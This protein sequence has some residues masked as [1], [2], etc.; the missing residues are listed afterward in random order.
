[1]QSW[2]K[3]WLLGRLHESRIRTHNSIHVHD[4]L[5][6]P[7]CE[8]EGKSTLSLSDVTDTC[9]ASGSGWVALKSGWDLFS[10]LEIN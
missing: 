3:K 6:L 4:P 8:N 1:M 9:L 5:I 7:G 10:G 2:V